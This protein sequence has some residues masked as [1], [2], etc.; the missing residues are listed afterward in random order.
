MTPQEFAEAAL[1]FASEAHRI[2]RELHASS[3]DDVALDSEHDFCG[4]CAVAAQKEGGRRSPEE[5]ALS[6]AANFGKNAGLHQPH[7][8]V[9]YGNADV[10][11]TGYADFHHERG[12]YVKDTGVSPDDLDGPTMF[13]TA[14]VLGRRNVERE[15]RLSFDISRDVHHGIG[16]KVM[17]N[18]PFAVVFASSSQER[19]RLMREWSR[20]A[21]RDFGRLAQPLDLLLPKRKR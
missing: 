16:E 21:L 2:Q 7:V 13:E 18:H 3:L 11:M 4:A 1:I 17:R 19:I 5:I 12:I 10:P 15:L 8:T 9:G 14:A 6:C 20:S